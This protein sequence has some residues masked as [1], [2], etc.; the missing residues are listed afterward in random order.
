M[1]NAAAVIVALSC[2]CT[3]AQADSPAPADG[4]LAAAAT[5]LLTVRT[6]S[7]AQAMAA[8]NAVVAACVSQKYVVSVAIVDQDGTVTALLRGDGAPA[9]TVEAARRKAY[10]AA[11]TG[12]ATR[13][14]EQALSPH[15]EL[16]SARQ[17][18]GFLLLGGAL[19]VKIGT[20]VLGAIGVSGA[21]TIEADEACA[22]AGLR[23]I[24]DRARP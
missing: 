2:L 1:K 10:T 5:E 22:R 13:Q 12:V 7:L 20:E 14:L 24:D 3:S 19:P 17:I 18:D 8:A 21:P 9:Y 4:L 16:W 15:P 11:S 6:L 23:A